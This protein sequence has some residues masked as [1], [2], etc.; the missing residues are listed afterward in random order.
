MLNIKKLKEFNLKDLPLDQLPLEELPV[1][2]VD[3]EKLDPNNIAESYAKKIPELVLYFDKQNHNLK[4]IQVALVS[5]DKYSLDV[6]E[7]KAYEPKFEDFAVPEESWKCH[8]EQAKPLHETN[9]QEI[10]KEIT[11][12]PDFKQI[13]PFLPQ[14]WVIPDLD[15]LINQFQEL[16]GS[17]LKK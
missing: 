1:D 5:G 7:I 11:E 17:S 9:F 2:K 16:L 14:G 3:L 12:N 15:K 10:M 4:K 13:A 8:Q 6:V